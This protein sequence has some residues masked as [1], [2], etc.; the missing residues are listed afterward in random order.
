MARRKRKVRAASGLRMVQSQAR[1]LLTRLR[2]EIRDREALLQRL[3]AQ[4][5]G[6]GRFTGGGG[7]RRGG[8][9]RRRGAGRRARRINWNKVLARLPKEFKASNVRSIPGVK[10]KRSSEIFAAITRWIEAG[11]VKRKARGA[12]EK[13]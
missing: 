11:S 6:L 5:T 8:A 13:A 10:S 1:S 9:V 2:R 4:E 12:Y 3:K 7:G